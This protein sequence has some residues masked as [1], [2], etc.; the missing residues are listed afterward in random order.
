M[1]TLH[2]EALAAAAARRTRLGSALAWVHCCGSGA[3]PPVPPEQC[4]EERGEARGVA[5]ARGYPQAAGAG[6]LGIRGW[7]CG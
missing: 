2:G 4:G 5:P 7:F 1:P 6:R 3:V